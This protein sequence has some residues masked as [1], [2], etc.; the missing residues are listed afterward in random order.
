ML[1][2]E[3][4]SFSFIAR[5]FTGPPDSPGEESFDA[6]AAALSGSPPG[7]GR[8]G[9]TTPGTIWWLMLSRSMSVGLRLRERY[10]GWDHGP[11]TGENQDRISVYEVTA[12]PGG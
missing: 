8:S 4:E 6:V 3:L 1:P 10:Q 5:T 7:A 2:A 12:G 11:F 9:C